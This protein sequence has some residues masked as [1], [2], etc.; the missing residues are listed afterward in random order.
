MLIYLQTEIPSSSQFLR[1]SEAEAFSLFQKEN[2]S[3]A[4]LKSEI[5]LHGEAH[6]LL[7][8]KRFNFVYK[9]H[10]VYQMQ[11]FVRIQILY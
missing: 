11:R 7:Y 2:G 10:F 6:A 8:F 1:E 5:V 4:Y 3:A 9:V